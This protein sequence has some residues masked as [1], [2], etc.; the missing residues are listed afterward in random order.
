[1]KGTSFQ[2]PLEF[3]LSVDGESWHQGD[4]IAGVLVVKNQSGETLALGDIGVHLAVGQLKK[5]RLKSSDAFTPLQSARVRSSETLAPQKEFVFGWKFE[6]DRN[7]PITDATASPF[8]LYG[9]GTGTEKLA[10]L[11]LPIH[12][13][14]VIEE[15]LKTFQVAFR[16]VLKTRKS[17]KGWVELK[18]VPPSGKNFATLEY[19][20]SGFRFDGD[21]LQV[22]YSFHAKKLE[23]SAAAIDTKK[24]KKESEWTFAR[25][26]Y[27][28]TSGRFN[29]DVIEAAIREALTLVEIPL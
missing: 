15:F 21:A 29:H 23:A 18:L 14:W 27:L 8:L 10:Q 1:M 24:I 2:K 12:P 17:T 13:Y 22:K 16:F 28:T 3:N 6:T 9:Q 11:Q 25:D 5:V 7:C 4:P 20:N 19:L 26:Q